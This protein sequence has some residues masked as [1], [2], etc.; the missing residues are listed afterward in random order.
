MSPST[1]YYGNLRVH[2]ELCPKSES[3]NSHCRNGIT[4]TNTNRI[5][6]QWKLFNNIQYDVGAS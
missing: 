4:N 2:V 6:N 5:N 3:D 1:Q